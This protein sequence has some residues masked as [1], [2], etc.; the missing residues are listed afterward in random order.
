M[1]KQNLEK[2]AALRIERRFERLN[3]L[4]RLGWNADGGGDF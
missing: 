1:V 3:G 4:L 2:I